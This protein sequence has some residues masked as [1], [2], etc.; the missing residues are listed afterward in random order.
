MKKIF[1]FILLIP[2]CS[3]AQISD[4]ICGTWDAV[5]K[6][7]TVGFREMGLPIGTAD[8]TFDSEEDVRTRVFLKKV[9]RFIYSDPKKG[10]QYLE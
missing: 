9:V 6:G 8:D 1:A 5:M 2:L 4:A 10:L 3:Q 7:Q